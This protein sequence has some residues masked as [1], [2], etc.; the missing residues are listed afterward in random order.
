MSTYNT[1]NPLGST[2]P[3]DLYDNAGNLDEAVNTQGDRW[4]D[5]LGNERVSLRAAVDPSGFAQSALN[6]ANRA[7]AARDAALVNANAASINADVYA[8]TAAGIAGTSDGEQFQVVEGAEV[9]R[10][11]NE[12]G[13][14]V[15]V[16]RYPAS[17]FVNIAL[18]VASQ[19]G[20]VSGEFYADD[21]EQ[22]IYSITDDDGQALASWSQNGEMDANPSLEMAEKSQRARGEFHTSDD[23]PAFALTDEGGRPL[24]AVD[25]NGQPIVPFI[26][27]FHT[28]DGQP[29]FAWTD[30]NGVVFYGIDKDGRNVVGG[31]DSD[32]DIS[33]LP[34]GSQGIFAPEVWLD[35]SKPKVGDFEDGNLYTAS[36]HTL[37]NEPSKVF[38]YF[39]ELMAEFPEYITSSVLGLDEWGNEIRQYTFTP[40]K[41]SENQ[42]GGDWENIGIKNP[43]ICLVG[44]LH[45][46]ERSAALANVIF[47]RNLCHRWDL[48][49]RLAKLRHEVILRFVPVACPTGLDNGSRRNLNGV[50]L[51]RNFPTDWEDATERQP[52][53]KGPSPASELETQILMDLPVSFP[54]CDVFI[55]HHGHNISSINQ[56]IGTYTEPEARFAKIHMDSILPEQLRIG[57][58][59]PPL[60]YRLS[61][62]TAGGIVRHLNVEHG[63]ASYLLESSFL[64]WTDLASRRKFDVFRVTQFIFDLAIRQNLKT[65]EV[66]ND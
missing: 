30:K 49:E 55:D 21:D 20:L 44:A 51:N 33:S 38:A 45:G 7:E 50:D 62:V 59:H 1:G 46:D 17:E 58:E 42:Y 47:A 5:R 34:S 60:P 64:S 25:E 61:Q 63:V 4:T 41:L 37:V 27:E 56:W 22:P 43:E 8:D 13:D 23:Q 32:F 57:G 19:P 52:G 3:R 36:V 29:S 48:D 53:D 31:G 15:E 39:D 24:Y 28:E 18:D 12:S 10:Y 9:V 6:D 11:R 14:A 16:A 35:Y 54:D 2:D 66:Q 40:E 65:Q 26:S